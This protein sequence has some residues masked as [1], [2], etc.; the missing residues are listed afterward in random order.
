MDKNV[1]GKL[2]T[3]DTLQRAVRESVLL[4][5]RLDGEEKHY[6]ARLLSLSEDPSHFKKKTADLV[7]AQFA[8]KIQPAV[9]T[10]DA[11]PQAEE[12]WILIT[13]LEPPDGN[14]RIRKAAK[15]LLGFCLGLEYFRTV[16]TF[17]KV[18]R[19]ET[20]QAIELSW[21]PGFQ[22][23]TKRLQQR[24]EIPN[25][26]LLEVQVHKRGAEPFSAQVVDISQ[27]GL[28]FTCNIPPVALESGDRI[29]VSIR[30]EILMGTP[31]NTYGTVTTITKARDSKDVQV[32]RQLYGVRF[33]MLSVADAMTVDRLVEA[34]ESVAQGPSPGGGKHTRK[35][36][37]V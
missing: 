2:S 21:P 4:E 22:V 33:V 8:A 19:I 1:P 31:I 14:M 36:V 7:L 13:P 11:V 18:Q 15:V 29:G 16:V 3:F 6:G 28:S 30:G 24:V 34:V 25:E 23:A 27:G 37:G 35:R 26:M 20:G 5:V 10:A 17:R 32:S 9:A 12:Q